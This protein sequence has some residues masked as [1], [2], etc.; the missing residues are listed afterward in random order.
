MTK[1]TWP[2]LASL[3]ALPLAL[4]LASA[5]ARAEVPADAAAELARARQLE[6]QGGFDKQA[7]EAYQH[8]SDLAHGQSALSLLGMSPP[9]ECRNRRPAWALPSIRVSSD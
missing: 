2:R 3:L 5:P 9:A 7:C 4:T 8:A 6:T 1:I